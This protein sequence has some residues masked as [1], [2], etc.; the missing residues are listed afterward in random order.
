MSETVREPPAHAR[1]AQD[2][3]AGP[4]ADAVHLGDDAIAEGAAG[5]AGG[6]ER[7]IVANV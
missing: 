3:V 2:P 5:Q 4:E 1:L 7:P 6:C